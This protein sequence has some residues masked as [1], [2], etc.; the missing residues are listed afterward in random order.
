MPHVPF[1]RVWWGQQ[2]TLDRGQVGAGQMLVL[3]SLRRRFPNFLG[4]GTL[5]A[6][7][8]FHGILDQKKYLTVLLIS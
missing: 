6:S 5:S 1:S 4:S 8:T 2:P 7:G 3:I